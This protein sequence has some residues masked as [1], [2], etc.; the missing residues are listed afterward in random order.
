MGRDRGEKEV[1]PGGQK[2]ENRLD[3]AVKETLVG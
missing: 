2:K 3:K 1:R